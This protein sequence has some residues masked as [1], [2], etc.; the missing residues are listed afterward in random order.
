MELSFIGAVPTNGQ[1]ISAHKLSS[2]TLSKELDALKLGHSDEVLQKEEKKEEINSLNT[3]EYEPASPN[4]AL[5]NLSAFSVNFIPP[6]VGKPK[7]TV[8]AASRGKCPQDAAAVTTPVT[9]L[10]PN[11]SYGFTVAERPTFFVYL[12]ETSATRAFFSLRDANEDYYY[13]TIFPI[14]SNPGI[15][16]FKLPEDAPALEIGKTYNWSLV[17]ICGQALRPGDPKVEGE[18]ERIELDPAQMSKLESMSAFERA[19]WYGLE[20]IW[21]DTLTAIA[22]LK[23]SNPKNANIASTWEELLRSVG[24]E[25]I[26]IQPLVQ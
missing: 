1:E 16:S 24:L 14:A 26:S 13:Q 11:T 20:G 12:P 9:P 10:I 17:T 15:I 21:Y 5:N 3:T 8:G 25:A 22:T 23:Q 4:Q 6:G 7:H 19:T 2:E 18:I